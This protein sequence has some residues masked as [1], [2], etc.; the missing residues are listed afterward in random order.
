MKRNKRRWI[1][2]ALALALVLGMG[3][4]AFAATTAD[5]LSEAQK[6]KLYALH[7]EQS[8]LQQKR[9]DTYLELG[10]IT[11]D[12]AAA[13]KERMAERDA[14]IKENGILPGGFG[15]GGPGRGGFGGGRGACGGCG[16]FA[17]GGF[18]NGFANG[19]L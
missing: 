11:E 5:T 10:L 15:N 18:G 16:G 7:E 6:E 2:L 4:T 12:Q 1:V 8:A 9:I 13:M 17:N 19:A 14:Y 3:A